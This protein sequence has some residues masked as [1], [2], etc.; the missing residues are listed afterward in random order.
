[1]DKVM[2]KAIEMTADFWALKLT[3]LKNLDNGD[4]NATLFAHM[5]DSKISKATPEQ[6]LKFREV[7]TAVLTQ[8]HEE[9]ED[10][11]IYC[12]YDPDRILRY[13]GQQAGFYVGMTTFGFKTGS[14]VRNNQLFLGGVPHDIIIED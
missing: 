14:Y 2:Q 9:G 12:D 3:G 8:L 7:L 5:V 6:I 4:F 1:M 10:I 13:C 11:S